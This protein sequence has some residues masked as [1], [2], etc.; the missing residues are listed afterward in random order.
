MLSS[1]QKSGEIKRAFIGIQYG[2]LTPTL[3]TQE[4]ISLQNGAYVGKVVKNSPAEQ[5]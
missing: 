3:A 1:V 5:A 2:I 4:G